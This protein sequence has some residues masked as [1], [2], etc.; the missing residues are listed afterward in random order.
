MTRMIEIG[1]LRN[2]IG[3]LL[4]YSKNVNIWQIEKY[5]VF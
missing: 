5:V 2:E 4:S 1:E 3:L